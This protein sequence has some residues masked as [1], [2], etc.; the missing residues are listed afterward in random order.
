[1][2]DI[3]DIE[4]AGERIANAKAKGLTYADFRSVRLTTE[5]ISLLDGK[6]DKIDRKVSFGFGVRVLVDGA[7]GFTAMPGC[8]EN[9]ARQ[10][11][12]SAIAIARA[13]ARLQSAPVTLAPIKAVKGTYQTPLEQDPFSVSLTDKV[14]LLKRLDANLRRTEGITGSEAFMNFRR[15]EKW[16]FSSEGA[17]ITQTIVHSGGGMAATA[18]R[19]RR[20][21]GERSYPTSGGQ[22][23]AGG[24]EVIAVMNLEAACRKTA[25]EAMALLDAPMPG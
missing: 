18:M 21:V 13:S 2:P 1:M 16:F 14:D 24:Y 8:D 17:V 5:D 3:N 12:D 19:S 7:W 22:H 10:A 6:P 15:E 25:E 20:E 9:L 11:L 4:K 23:R